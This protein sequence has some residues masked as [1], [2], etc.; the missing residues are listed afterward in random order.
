MAAA[1]MVTQRPLAVFRAM[2]APGPDSSPR[3]SCGAA[4]ARTSSVCAMARSV[5]AGR[6][7]RCSEVAHLAAGA[8]PR[9]R[10]GRRFAQQTV[11][12]EPAGDHVELA[13]G[14]ARPKLLRPGAIELDPVVVGG[15]QIE[16]LAHAM[17]GAAVERNAGRNETAERIRKRGARGIEDR[18]MIEPRAVGRRRRPA[19]TLP[20]IE[21]DVVMIAAGRDEGGAVAAPLR[22][23]EAEHAAIEFQRPLEIGDL[24]MHI[25][26]PDPAIDRTRRRG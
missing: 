11:E 20:G 21:R 10:P 14:R 24:Q 16:R 7:Q 13:L 18:E 22:E 17:V 9:P 12:V 2:T 4:S 15:A 8:I 6:W 1:P 3:G 26:D 19:E 23:L 25:T 5:A